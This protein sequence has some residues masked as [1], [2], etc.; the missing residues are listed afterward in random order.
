M[1]ESGGEPQRTGLT[2]EVEAEGKGH[3]L[4]LAGDIDAS[5]VGALLGCSDDLAAMGHVDQVLDLGGVTF[6]D[7]SGLGAL[8][9]LRRQLE[10]AGGSLGLACDNEIVLRLL[11]LTSLDTVLPVY[12]TV[13]EALRDGFGG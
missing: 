8:V 5:S 11:R 1:S 13:A 2:I 12:P 7:S 4:A 6:L 3:V 9:S 10:S